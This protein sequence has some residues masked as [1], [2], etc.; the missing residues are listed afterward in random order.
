MLPGGIRV[1]V[2]ETHFPAAEPIKGG[3]PM[4]VAETVNDILHSLGFVP[5]DE[6]G[7]AMRYRCPG[8]RDCVAV[9]IAEE[10]TIG[11]E[12]AA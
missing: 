3:V 9:C 6:P 12:T 4:K 10:G 5:L 1:R 11:K 2:F 8:S 7:S